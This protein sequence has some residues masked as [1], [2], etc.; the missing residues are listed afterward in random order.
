MRT[1]PDRAS[2]TGRRPAARPIDAL[3]DL[4]TTPSAPPNR[5]VAR[6]GRRSDIHDTPIEI[7]IRYETVHGELLVTPAPGYWHQRVVGRLYVLLAASL[8]R[9]GIEDALMSPAD[10][11]FG[12]DTLVQPDL[13]VA[14]CTQINRTGRCADLGPLYRV[15][16]ILS[17]SSLR[18]DRFTKRRLY[19]EQ[20]IPEYWV[21]DI[22]G[23]QVEVWTPGTTWPHVERER[24]AW[25]HPAVEEEC[26]VELSKVFA[27]G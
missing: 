13:F 7:P 20:R 12:D 8:A 26:V 18:A 15:I 2:A 19:Q 22:E 6:E 5:R 21:V 11:S 16:E 9:A 14:D 3:A 4:P 1:V 17:P 24:L 23:E 27:K 25:R 10:V